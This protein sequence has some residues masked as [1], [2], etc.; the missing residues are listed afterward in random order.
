MIVGA[1]LAPLMIGAY[2]ASQTVYFLG[3]SDQ[4]FVTLY[5]GLPYDLPAG[6]DLYTRNFETGVP[7][8][9]LPAPVRRTVTEHKLRAFDDATDLVKR[10]ER[11]ELAGQ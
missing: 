6:T 3:T 11:G 7:V 9:G 10:I 4:G 5:R 1:L 2:F 8:S